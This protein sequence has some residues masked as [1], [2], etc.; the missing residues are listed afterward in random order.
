M[1]TKTA[2][3][4]KRGGVKKTDAYQL[5][6][7]AIVAALEAGV[8]PWRQPW[9]ADVDAPR[10]LSSR[11][12]YRGVNVFLL[13]WMSMAKG[14][15]S[16]WW[17]TYKQIAERGGQVRKGEKGT[18][19]VF[20]RMLEVKDAA[21]KDGKKKIPMLRHFT[22]FNADQCDELK[23]PELAPQI[24]FVPWKRAEKNLR[25]Y[26]KSGTGPKLMHGSSKAAY[27]PLR[28]TVIMPKP[29]TFV[30]SEAY[31]SVF[32][33]ELTHSTGHETRLK[34]EGIV[35]TD[36]TFGTEMYGKEEL[37]AEMG[38]AFLCGETGVPPQIEMSA[39]YIAAWLKTIKGDPKLV[40]AAAGAAQ[41]AADLI[42]GRTYEKEEGAS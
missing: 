28:D 20:W 39:G 41:R 9:T 15:T 27:S 3:K 35:G 19:V 10:S 36:T 31:Y 17:G 6:T 2:A 11:K 7:N 25:G 16:P 12:P 22:V 33:H 24:E 4:P 38:A 18:A 13:M 26:L 8:V 32:F 42:L 37:I 1:T 29:T 34:R 5:I 30:S 23:V 40:I 21:A 14:Y